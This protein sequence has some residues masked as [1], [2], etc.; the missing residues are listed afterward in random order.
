MESGAFVFETN[1]IIKAV[2]LAYGM[3]KS[4][5]FIFAFKIWVFQS[6][7]CEEQSLPFIEEKR[8]EP[9]F[10]EVNLF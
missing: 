9:L 2:H 10:I 8:L 1:I 5:A 4:H 3:V 7:M 6:I